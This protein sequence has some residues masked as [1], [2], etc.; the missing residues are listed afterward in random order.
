[1][2]F[3]SGPFLSPPLG[4]GRDGWKLAAGLLAVNWWA[5]WGPRPFLSLFGAG[6][7]PPEGGHLG[8]LVPLTPIST[9]SV[10][11]SPHSLCEP[12][13]T[14]TP[15]LYTHTILNTHTHNHL[16]W[17][18]GSRTRERSPQ[19]AG[20]G[21][22]GEAA[23]SRSQETGCQGGWDQGLRPGEQGKGLGGWVE[24]RAGEEIEN[25]SPKTTQRT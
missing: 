12:Q 20:G 21:H 10:S 2:G 25:W 3:K 15:S 7:A 18:L 6:S 1:M 17:F 13:H 5:G 16:S 23:G 9:L 19:E 14:H 4:P 8:L 11:S 24:Q 22:A